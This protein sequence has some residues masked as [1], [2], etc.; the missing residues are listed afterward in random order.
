MK[1]KREG[2]RTKRYFFLEGEREGVERGKAPMTAYTSILVCILLL[3]GVPGSA[4]DA[5]YSLDLEGQDDEEEEG[6]RKAWVR[7]VVLKKQAAVARR[8]AWVT[9][10]LMMVLVVVRVVVM[11]SRTQEMTCDVYVCM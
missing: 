5:T 6:K 3:T 9:R 8:A 10:R 1:T 4:A 7:V 2:A 11:M